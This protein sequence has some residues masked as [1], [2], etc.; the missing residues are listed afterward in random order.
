[1]KEELTEKQQAFLDALFG[2]A[3]GDPK[4]AAEIAGYQM[5]AS[6][7]M[8]M[9]KDHIV[10]KAQHVLALYSPKAAFALAD[11]VG[12]DGST[13]PGV[14]S[15]MA[16]AKEILD[17]VG[18][19]KQEKLNISTDVPVGLFILPPKDP[20]NDGNTEQSA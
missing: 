17:R 10:E 11:A 5:Q 15:R 9:L 1:M 8:G 3:Q 6:K 20:K 4:K 14:N 16:A 2:E 12:E 18:I 7:I 13:A 19:V